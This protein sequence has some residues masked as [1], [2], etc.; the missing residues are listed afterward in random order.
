MVSN[1]FALQLCR[2]PDRTEEI[3]FGEEFDEGGNECA[4][5]FDLM[6]VMYQAYMEYGQDSEEFH[7]LA[8]RRIQ[9][10]SEG[11]CV[12]V[13]AG[14]CVL[15]VI[16]MND[17]SIFSFTGEQKERYQE[18]ELKIILQQYPSRHSHTH[19]HLQL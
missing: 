12:G 18:G 16:I 8:D 5:D 3:L 1:P 9:G 17:Y 10:L 4:M 15:G 2:I 14:G 13:G 6:A 11:V 19:T 7:S